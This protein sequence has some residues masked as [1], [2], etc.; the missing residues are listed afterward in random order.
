MPKIESSLFEIGVLD[1]LAF[2]DTPLHRIDPRIKL[3]TTLC[4]IVTVVSYNH[5]EFSA[6]LPL[7]L[8]P[9]ALSAS[10]QLP[11]AYL[12]R[13]LLIASP[14]ALL[15]GMFN[16]L[17]DHSTLLQIGG[18]S[19]SGGWVSFA[20]IMLRFTLTVSA[21][22]ILVAS[23]GFATVCMAL[24]RM[25]ISKVFTTQLLFLYRYIFILTD[26]G[27]RMMRARNLRSFDK[28]GT[29]L[30]IYGSMLGQLLLRTMDRAQRIHQ[31]MLCRGF[32]GDIRLNRQFRLRSTDITF[33]AGWLTFFILA[34]T[35][36]LPLA[37]GQ[38][39]MGIAA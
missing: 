5:Y 22:L 16:P 8:Y 31:A 28:R 20:S 38:F 34:R 9:I 19:I 29:G 32:T 39:V 21:A 1:Q 10:G 15:I 30:K 17:F 4:F 6:L 23:T 36:N 7:I 25:G 37:V 13:K 14:F 11:G 26:E 24:G 35:C 3:I 2:Q 18:L 27:L 33:A 12:W